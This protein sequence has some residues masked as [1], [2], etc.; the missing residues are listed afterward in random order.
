MLLREPV[1]YHC[2]LQ[3]LM[4]TDIWGAS[5]AYVGYLSMRSGNS[6]PNHTR[7]LGE[8]TGDSVATSRVDVRPYGFRRM[9][10]CEVVGQ[11]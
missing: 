5:P 3:A 11:V 8:G 2:L 7:R 1:R 10:G 4:R 9:A 6:V